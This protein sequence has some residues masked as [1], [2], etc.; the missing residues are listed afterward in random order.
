MYGTEVISLVELTVPTLR[1]V[2]EEIQED[3]DEKHAEGRL[4]DLEGLEEKHEVARRRSQRYRQ[5]MAKAYGQ[6]V[7]PRIFAE[8]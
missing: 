6:T 8:G 2:L 3:K 1:V 5:K 4:A 7:H